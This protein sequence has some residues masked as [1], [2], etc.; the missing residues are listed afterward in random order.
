VTVHLRAREGVAAP[1][2]GTAPVTAIAE[3]GQY[4]GTVTWSPAVSG[5]FAAGTVYTATVS[6]TAK[7]G[8]TFQGVA[9]DFFAVAGAKASN[10]ADSGVVTAVFKAQVAANIIEYFWVDQHDKLATTSG[11]SAV[12]K[13]GETLT[14]KAQ[15]TGYT[16]KKWYLNDIETVIK[17][18]TFV[19]SSSKT[20]THTVTLIVEK[21]GKPYNTTISITVQK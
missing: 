21:D 2:I 13:T 1:A 10:A 18:D 17:E 8:Y 9:K 4:T 14:I 19:F 3:N 15:G 12:I 5:T 16:V 6:L 11:G 20:G 7:T